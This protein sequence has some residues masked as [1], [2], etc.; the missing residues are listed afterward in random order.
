M[1]IGMRLGV[2]HPGAAVRF[3]SSSDKRQS[4]TT[5]PGTAFVIPAPSAIVAGNL[6][7]GG[8]YEDAGV[9][10]WAPPAGWTL[11]QDN[12]GGVAANSIAVYYKIA[13]GSEP[14]SYTF[15]YGTTSLNTASA[16]GAI[17]QYEPAV[18]G[19]SAKNLSVATGGSAGAQTAVAPSITVDG[20][21]TGTFSAI[22]VGNDIGDKAGGVTMSLTGGPVVVFWYWRT[23]RAVN[24]SQ[25]TIANITFPAGTIGRVARYDSGNPSGQDGIVAFADT[26]TV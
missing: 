26:L 13:T 23:G 14:G 19:V 20:V 18:I 17:V 5:G 3:V 6:L 2:K 21:P 12:A 7:I 4:N 15:T 24:T 1:T 10:T 9:N 11:V 8:F 22:A 16:V 25:G